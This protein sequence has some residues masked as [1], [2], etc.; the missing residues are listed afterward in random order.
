MD[1]VLPFSFLLIC[2]SARVLVVLSKRVVLNDLMSQ[3]HGVLML[4]DYI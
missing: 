1:L 3:S 4:N 2:C